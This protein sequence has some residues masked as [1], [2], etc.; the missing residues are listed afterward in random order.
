VFSGLDPRS[1]EEYVYV[2]AVA[3]GA[4]GGPEEDGLDGV[5]VHITNTA[6]LPVE[7]L[8]HAF[9]LVVERYEFVPDSGGPGEF[10][11]GLGLR[12]DIRAVGHGA[13][14]SAHGDRHRRPARGAE[15]GLPGRC[16]A[17]LV[18]PVLRVETPGGGGY[19]DPGARERERVLAELR[20]GLVSPAAARDVFGVSV[21][22]DAEGPTV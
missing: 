14:F 8:E 4:G 12:R 6:N 3:G 11:G 22:E 9:P 17:Y 15:G 18:S 5:Q 1:K 7:C 19:G 2:E 13:V 21:D 20:D 16:G 10:R